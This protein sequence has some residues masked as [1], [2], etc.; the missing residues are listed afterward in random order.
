MRAGGP[1]AKGSQQSSGGQK[2]GGC[3]YTVWG[4]G[5]DSQ[6]PDSPPGPEEPAPLLG[7]CETGKVP[8]AL[9]VLCRLRR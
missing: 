1:Q 4:K 3:F 9:Q 5:G 6:H 2:P 7:I 8:P